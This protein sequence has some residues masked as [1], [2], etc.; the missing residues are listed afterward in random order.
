M[1]NKFITDASVIQKCLK[2]AI[3]KYPDNFGN[4]C[5][6]FG[7]LLIDQYFDKREKGVR[8]LFFEKNSVQP[9]EF[10]LMEAV[11]F[12]VNHHNEYSGNKI[13]FSQEIYNKLT[14]E[15][16]HTDPKTITKY[17]KILQILY[18]NN[19]IPTESVLP[20]KVND[21]VYDTNMERFGIITKILSPN[22]TIEMKT[23]DGLEHKIY[24]LALEYGSDRIFKY[25]TALTKIQYEIENIQEAKKLAQTVL[26]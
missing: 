22:T 14:N 23:F 9:Y 1:I 15:W 7:I 13:E 8:A 12:F 25:K 4:F 10:Y 5:D 16:Y 21:L 6:L 3:K 24:T 17:D 20:L 26:E 19:Y 2:E 11:K 18:Y